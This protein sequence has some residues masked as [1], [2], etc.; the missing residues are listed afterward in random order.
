[1]VSMNRSLL[2]LLCTALA[3]CKPLGEAEVS[4]VS[5]RLVG[6]EYAA[7]P[8]SDSAA[9]GLPCKFVSSG[10]ISQ[11]GVKQTG[12]ISG[13]L[14]CNDHVPFIFLAKQIGETKFAMADGNPPRPYPRNK[15]V[16]VQKL[17]KV[18]N[19]SKDGDGLELPELVDSWSGQCDFD[20]RGGT[21]FVALVRWNGESVVKGAP[22]IEA[23]WGFDLEAHRVV[24]LDSKRVACEPML[25]E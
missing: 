8:L 15:I 5:Q 7:V 16:A 6:L 24:K 9:E 2:L 12:W 17:P 4:D 14:L 25:M 13:Q 1:M 22:G 23:V 10:D 11:A 3:A 18:S 19:F 21:S 20:G